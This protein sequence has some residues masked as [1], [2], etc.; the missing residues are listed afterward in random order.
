M[1]YFRV[2]FFYN[3]LNNGN[4]PTEGLANVNYEINPYVVSRSEFVKR[5]NEGDHF[6]SKIIDSDKIFLKGSEHELATMEI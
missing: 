3:G 5:R 4:W 1:H 6:I 2:R